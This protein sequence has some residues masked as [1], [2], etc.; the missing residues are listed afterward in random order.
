MRVR[1][2]G[3]TGQFGVSRRDYSG[4]MMAACAVLGAVSWSAR[5]DSSRALQAV[6]Y[7]QLDATHVQLVLTL[8]E[9][10]PQ[11]SVFS[12]DKPARL[13]LDLPGT[14]LAVDSRYG[15]IN[16]GKVRGYA[17]AE[18]KDR[19]RLVVELSDPVPNQ[20]AVQG[21]KILLTLDAGAPAPSQATAS[22]AG[23]AAAGS[24]S[25]IDFRRGENGE[26]R[27]VVTLSNPHTPVD[28]QEEGGKIV[29]R[30]KD[31]TLPSR[32]ARRYDVLDFATPA[33]YV[34]ASQD[35]RDVKIAV[36]PTRTGDFDQVAYQ[37]GDAFTVELQPL[38]AQK[39][40]ER[41]RDNPQ[42]TGE[43]ISLSFQSV[44]VR[45]LLQIIA[46]VAG[47]NMVV[48]DSV[49]GQLAM[50][51][52]NVPWDQALDIILRT[53]GLGLRR[54]GNVM[55]VAPL[56]E[57]AQRDKAELETQKQKIQLAPLRSEI[58]Q[59]NYAK[60]SD[61]ASLLK[62]GDSSILSERGRVT[63]D[64]RTNTL[65]VLET[66]EKLADIRALISRLDVPV[67][68]V[69]IES[70]I[71]VA[72]DSF[73]RDIGTRFGFSKV[74]NIGNNFVSTTNSG[75]NNN[76]TIGS[77]LDNLADTDPTNDGQVTLPLPNYNVNLPA[78][79]SVAT[80]PASIALAVLG[81]D[82]LVD[83]ELSALQAEGRGEVVSS[84]R[85]ITANGKQ[86]TIEQ[87]REI[88]Y[89]ESTSSGATSVTFKKAVLSLDVT[90]Q[91]TPDQR[92]IM[93]LTVNNDSVGQLVTTSSGGSVPSIDTRKVKTQVLVENGQTVVLG[94]VYQ[95]TTNDVVN[96]VPLLGDIPLLGYLFRNQ[97]RQNNKNE[98]LIFITPKL[99]SDN[100][101]VVQP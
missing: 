95:R 3:L 27:I 64:E 58:I 12:I 56:Q 54:E 36:T 9:P 94:G 85:V 88:P 31:A 83:L 84:P 97:Q 37:T 47:T 15:K 98:L 25:G 5:A 70:R 14:H 2:F 61:V 32:L 20:I 19:T 101:N 4:W 99:L 100:L 87:G 18:A 53:K 60:A 91:I 67:R 22:P 81:K 65:L 45:A 30:F 50:R 23:A 44:D 62:S 93:D 17:L 77:R 66:R 55:L 49:S 13:A 7:S 1:L 68:Q 6:E 21:N 75:T 28:V 69:L 41:R 90:P 79:P 78:T 26:G 40:E 39:L 92:V 63:V 59:V 52:Q 8:S 73:E 80:N 10:A 57:I 96:K 11:P 16:V 89:N 82:F 72:S 29:A 71:V 48:S 38:S 24:V 76:T 35:G 86:A 42:Y 33:K 34:D 74:G 51:L 43:R 46:D